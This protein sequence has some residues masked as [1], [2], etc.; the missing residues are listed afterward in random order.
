MCPCGRQGGACRT[1]SRSCT[2]D[3]VPHVAE[4]MCCCVP[5]LSV[6][7][8]PT[9]HGGRCHWPDSHSVQWPSCQHVHLHADHVSRQNTGQAGCLPLTRVPCPCRGHLVTEACCK[10]LPHSAHQPEKLQPTITACVVCTVACCRNNT[11]GVDSLGANGFTLV[12]PANL[13]LTAYPVPAVSGTPTGGLM[14][15]S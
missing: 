3:T 10:P 14:V 9:E 1:L 2:L 4:R 13:S 5:V 7:A 12:L 11:L 6:F 15:L 8:A